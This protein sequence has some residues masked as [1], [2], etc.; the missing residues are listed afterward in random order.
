MLNKEEET[1]VDRQRKKNKLIIQTVFLIHNTH[2]YFKDTKKII[3]LQQRTIF[4]RFNH[5]IY[6]MKEGK[7]QIKKF[8]E[9]LN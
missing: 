3:K 1:E 5:L 2:R 9:F 7:E 4:Q 6:N 8:K